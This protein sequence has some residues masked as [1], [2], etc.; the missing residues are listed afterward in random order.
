MYKTTMPIIFSVGFLTFSQFLT[1][2]LLA[3][4]E[5]KKEEGNE[6]ENSKNLKSTHEKDEKKNEKKNEETSRILKYAFGMGSTPPEKDSFWNNKDF[7]T[8]KKNYDYLDEY[9]KDKVGNELNRRTYFNQN[10]FMSPSTARFTDYSYNLATAGTGA[11]HK[12]KKVVKKK[13]KNSSDFDSDS[14]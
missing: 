7:K 10:T 2:P 3:S 9:E 12:K 5:N 1:P 13:K 8:Y 4:E 6:K 11:D 14:D